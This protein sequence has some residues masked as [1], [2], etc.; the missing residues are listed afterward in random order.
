VSKYESP[1]GLVEITCI[2]YDKG[3]LIIRHLFETDFEDEFIEDYAEQVT[4]FEQ[5]N[6][7]VKHLQA[8]Y[9]LTPR[10]N[11]TEEARQEN[12]Q[13]WRMTTDRVGFMY[14]GPIGEWLTEDGYTSSI[15][16]S[17]DAIGWGEEIVDLETKQE[18]T[19]YAKILRAKIGGNLPAVN[20]VVG[21]ET[22]F[23]ESSG[24]EGIEYDEETVYHGILDFTQLVFL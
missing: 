17:I 24:P 1:I 2:F 18:W 22:K 3:K 7:E 13:I 9:G 21:F 12:N 6:N 19:E 15:S 5:F 23:I 20:F 16:V 11:M 4:F 14:S 10:E 8:S